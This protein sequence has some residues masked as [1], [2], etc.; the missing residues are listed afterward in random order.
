MAE[1]Q[2]NLYTKKCLQKKKNRRE[3]K[4]FVRW[5]NFNFNCGGQLPATLLY[6]FSP[7]RITYYRLCLSAECSQKK[8]NYFAVAF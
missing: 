1:L 2:I 6:S 8:E 3:E 4:N 5:K 7:V